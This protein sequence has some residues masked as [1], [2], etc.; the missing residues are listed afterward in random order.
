MS[1]ENKRQKSMMTI[2]YNIRKF[3]LERGFTQQK[4][5]DLAKVS[6]STIQSIEKGSDP[7]GYVLYK[8]ARALEVSMNKVYGT[9][10][11]EDSNHGGKL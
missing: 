9:E 10:P 7:S 1:T 6:R 8:I 4:L 11:A 2:A 5:A 3:R